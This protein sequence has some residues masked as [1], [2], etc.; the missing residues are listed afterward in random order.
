[1]S[2]VRYPKPEVELYSLFVGHII[3][4]DVSYFQIIQIYYETSKRNLLDSVMLTFKGILMKEKNNIKNIKLWT[5]VY[6]IV[7]FH[8]NMV[9]SF[10]RKSF[11]TFHTCRLVLHLITNKVQNETNLFFVFCCPH[12]SELKKM[13]S[14]LLQYQNAINSHS[15]HVWN[16]KTK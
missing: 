9:F 15:L 12:S 2:L 5:H 11:N 7:R 6:K 10:I 8:C 13:F 16:I 14:A 4:R 3:G 1:M